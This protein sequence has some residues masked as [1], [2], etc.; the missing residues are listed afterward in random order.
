[1]RFLQIATAKS[2]VEQETF[3]KTVLRKFWSPGERSSPDGK[4][5]EES[6]WKDLERRDL[7]IGGIQ[8]ETVS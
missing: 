4:R 6:E 1:M 7:K 3:P 8:L 2:Q 5:T